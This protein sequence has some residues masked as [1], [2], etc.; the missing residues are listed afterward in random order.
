MPSTHC[1]VL[2]QHTTAHCT[3]LH[4]CTDQCY[5]CLQVYECTI[6]SNSCKYSKNEV[7]TR[8]NSILHFQTTKEAQKQKK[9]VKTRI[10]LRIYAVLGKKTSL[11]HMSVCAMSHVCRGAVTCEPKRMLTARWISCFNSNGNVSPPH[12]TISV[13]VCLGECVCLCVYVCV[14]VCMYMCMCNCVSAH[15]CLFAS[16]TVGRITNTAAEQSISMTHSNMWHDSFI[17]VKWLINMHEMTHSYLWNKSFIHVNWLIHMREMT[18]SHMWSA[19]FIFVKWLM[20]TCEV[21][22]SYA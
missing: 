1:N 14:C 18:H 17:Y 7:P 10:T 6:A 3:T 5:E 15:I 13:C 22:H 9:G 4:Q 21:P 11:K 16:S 19:S 2:Q 20:Y 12:R 8:L